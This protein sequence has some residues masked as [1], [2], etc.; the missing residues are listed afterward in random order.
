MNQEF[1]I[2]L[3]GEVGE[4]YI[5]KGASSLARSKNLYNRLSF[6]L[7]RY[8]GFALHMAEYSVAVVCQRLHYIKLPVVALW[9]S[10]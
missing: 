8:S 4:P 3:F 9:T 1:I 2:I 6:F 7:L 10:P 5:L